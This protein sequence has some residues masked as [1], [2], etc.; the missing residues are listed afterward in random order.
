MLFLV[1]MLWFYSLFLLT[2]FLS[3]PILSYHMCHFCFHTLSIVWSSCHPLLLRW[4][5]TIT[6]Y[7][8]NAFWCPDWKPSHHLWMN[9]P[10]CL[11]CVSSLWPCSP[12][13]FLALRSSL[14]FSCFA[15]PHPYLWTSLH[16]GARW[17]LQKPT[18][19]HYSVSPRSLSIRSKFSKLA[20]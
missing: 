8:L 13:L 3:T 15:S 16:P 20:F 2:L 10:C 14:H 17:I 4:P 6:I 5:K 9:P 1:K 11:H 7:P 18:P 12:L 19:Y